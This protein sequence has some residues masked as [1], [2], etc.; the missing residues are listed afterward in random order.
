MLRHESFHSIELEIVLLPPLTLTL[1]LLLLLLP[2]ASHVVVVV[3]IHVIAT[4]NQ[5]WD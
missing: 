3:P 1:Q 5:D 2:V 4:G